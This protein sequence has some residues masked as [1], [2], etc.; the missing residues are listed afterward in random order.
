MQEPHEYDNV[1]QFNENLL[2]TR[3]VQSVYSFNQILFT[4]CATLEEILLWWMIFMHPSAVISPRAC[5]NMA[6]NMSSQQ[7]HR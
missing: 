6:A 3:R 7:T 1:H 2:R 4:L 5:Y